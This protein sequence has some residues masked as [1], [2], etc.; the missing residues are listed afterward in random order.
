MV[1]GPGPCGRC[2]HTVTLV[3]SKLFI[4]GGHIDRFFDDIWAFEVQLW[5]DVKGVG[6]ANPVRKKED[7]Q[8][9]AEP[10]VRRGLFHDVDVDQ[11]FGWQRAEREAKKKHVPSCDVYGVE[12]FW[13]E[14]DVN[15][16]KAEAGFVC[17]RGE[18]RLP[19]LCRERRNEKTKTLKAFTGHT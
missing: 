5:K 18:E 11:L 7:A 6:K 19:L 14:Q 2:Y 8:E 16:V 10:T 3:G 4:F 12:E 13:F 17:A 9:Q 1:N 15:G